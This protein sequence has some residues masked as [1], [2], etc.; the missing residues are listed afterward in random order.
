MLVQLIF[1]S[2]SG[3]FK[4]ARVDALYAAFAARGATV[5]RTPTTGPGNVEIRADADLICVFGGDGTIRD[6]VNSMSVSGLWKPMCVYAG[7][8]VNLFARETGDCAAPGPFVDR[9]LNRSRDHPARILTTQD[10]ICLCCAS[11]GPDSWAIARLSRSLKKRVGRWAYL[12]AIAG[13]L[14]RWPR[15][16][17]LLTVDGE[18]M[19]CEAF[20]LVK[21]RF[22]A[23]RW[24]M[25]P[26]ASIYSDMFHV[27]A[28]KTARRRDFLLLAVTMLCHIPLK[29]L[30]N[31]RRVEAHSLSVTA[32]RAVPLQVDGDW[33][34]DLP[35][36]FVLHE[37]A[38]MVAGIG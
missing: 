16:R 21:G 20:F 17:L 27:I 8:T 5:E 7:G 28:M 32:D 37:H 26:D 35:A 4:P 25:A 6:V 22:Y 30:G 11:V 1:N 36:H 24:T 2:Q 34:G 14:D 38:L 9:V 10:G 31:I 29:A 33:V 19:T 12:W 15:D 23:G 13:M 3:S 18:E